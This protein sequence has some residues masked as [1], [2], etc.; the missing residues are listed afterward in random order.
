MCLWRIH[1]QHNISFLSHIGVYSK[2]SMKACTFSKA[3][4]WRTQQKQNA[5]SSPIVSE[6]TPVQRTKTSQ[7]RAKVVYNGSP[8]TCSQSPH[9]FSLNLPQTHTHSYTH[10]YTNISASIFTHCFAFRP[11][12]KCKA[13]INVQF[14]P[15]PVLPSWYQVTSTLYFPE[16]GEGG[17]CE[18]L[19]PCLP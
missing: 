4:T 3:F 7:A 1:K 12:A 9:T 17:K 16:G 15:S 14:A 11:T 5:Q 10:S 2:Q 8:V 18:G 13:C 6:C 19:T